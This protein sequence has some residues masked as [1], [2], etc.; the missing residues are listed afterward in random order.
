MIISENQTMHVELITENDELCMKF[1][2]TVLFLKDE[3]KEEK[4]NRYLSYV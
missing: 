1:C 4:K 3:S 2:I